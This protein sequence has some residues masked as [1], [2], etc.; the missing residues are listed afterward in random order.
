MGT[1]KIS[2]MSPATTPLTGDE[3]LEV[4]QLSGG[5]Y[6]TYN[7]SAADVAFA[8]AKYGA[9][10]DVTDQT[11]NI[12][13]ATAAK[14]GTDDIASK[15]VTVVASG[16]NKTRIT[17]S[18]AGTYMISPSLQFVN[19]GSSD[20]DVTVWLAKNGTAIPASAT[21]VTVPKLSDGG[22]AFFTSVFYVTVT[23]GQYIEIMWLPENAAITLEHTAAGAIAPAIP[24]A[25]VVTE[26]IDL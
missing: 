18:A 19:S 13:A 21:S 22:S 7:A 1:S 2:G 16:G 12:S 23:A 4:S 20:Y 11:G 24:S 3:L 10:H 17:Y 14:F 5:T 9:F 15:G 26:R 6:D 8:G 25:I